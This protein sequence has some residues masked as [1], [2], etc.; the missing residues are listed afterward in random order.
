MHDL[1]SVGDHRREAP[2]HRPS[3]ADRKWEHDLF[4]EVMQAPKD[5]GEVMREYGNGKSIQVNVPRSWTKLIS[6]VV[7]AIR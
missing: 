7:G 6:Q 5:P 4:D 1:R 3:R 2:K